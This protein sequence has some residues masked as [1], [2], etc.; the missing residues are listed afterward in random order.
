[1]AKVRIHRPIALFG[2]ARK[3]SVHLERRCVGSITRG[4]VFELDLPEGEHQLSVA[5]DWCVSQPITLNIQ[6][7]GTYEFSVHTR[8]L[9]AA[10]W[11][12]FAQPRSVFT[13]VPESPE[14][15]LA[16]A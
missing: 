5:M 8:F 10:I 2:V 14:G 7:D 13:L 15:M 9:L 6:G 11:C 4:G 1:M 3:L 16:S 12:C